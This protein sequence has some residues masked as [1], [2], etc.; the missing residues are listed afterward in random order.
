MGA[1]GFFHWSFSAIIRLRILQGLNQNFLVQFAPPMNPSKMRSVESQLGHGL[2]PGVPFVNSVTNSMNLPFMGIAISASMVISVF[3]VCADAVF[4]EESSLDKQL[5]EQWSTSIRPL[6]EKHCGTCHM[7]GSNEGGVNFDDYSDLEKIRQHASTWEQIRGVI[8]AEAMPPPDEPKLPDETKS[9]LVEWIRS[10]LHDVDCHCAPDPA[11]VTLRRLNQLEYD[12]TIRDLLNLEISPSRDL[13]FVSDDVGNGFD[14]QGE[15]L[16]L[17]PIVLEKYMQAAAHVAKKTIETDIDRLRTQRFEGET[18]AFAAKKVM[19]IR[20]SKGTYQLQIRMR[21][22]EKQTDTCKAKVTL[23]DQVIAEHDVP[24]K[25]DGRNS[26]NN[27]RHTLELDRGDY[28]ISIEYSDDAAPD[29]RSENDR[30]LVIESVRLTGPENGMPAFPIPHEQLV[31]ATPNQVDEVGGNEIGFTVAFHRVF[32]RL[33]PLA[34]RRSVTPEEIRSVVLICERAKSQGFSY[35]ESLQYGLQ[36]VLVSPNFL[37]LQESSNPNAAL[38]DFAIASRLSYFLWSSMPDS[39]LLE[40]AEAGILHDPAVLKQQIKRMLDNPKSDAL[41]KGFFSQWLGLR[42]LNKLEIDSSKF[43]AWS[44]KLRE[45]MIRETELFCGHLLKEGTLNDLTA[46][47]F[48]FVNPRMADYYGIPFEGKK[49]SEMLVR[50]RGF[51]GGRRS[52]NYESEDK[53]IRVELDKNRKGLL[54]HASVLSLTSNPTRSSPVKRGKWILEN[55]LG[56]PPPSA[57]PNVPTLEAAQAKEGAS[58]RE[59]LEVHRSNPS[60]AGCHKLMDPIGLGL[61]NFD[62]IG[63]WREKDGEI[64]IDSK[65]MLADGRQFDGPAQLVELLSTKKDQIVENFVRRMLTYALG[66]GLQRYDKCDIDRIIQYVNSQNQSLRA[67]VEAIVL[68]DA[69]LQ[70]PSNTARVSEPSQP[71]PKSE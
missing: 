10:S 57:P 13:A 26:N 35:E 44:P 54:T 24:T 42:S 62:A 6:I 52:G 59:R 1:K 5:R 38:D 69:F 58:L 22:G 60:C 18:L 9:K 51:G 27:F 8:R 2:M 32:K 15:V 71:S 65:G 56:D 39:K 40:L 14:N 36:A 4:A 28:I 53:W 33:L 66:R 46:A 23:G 17:S 67:T 63:K 34:Y 25:S 16:T 19:P 43:A 30:K 64:A 50:E 11:P 45:S 21:F 68:S 20:V 49:A 37:Y 61:E 48:T 7:K 41:L 31:V 47:N 55:V 70:K 29:K 12:N 3:L